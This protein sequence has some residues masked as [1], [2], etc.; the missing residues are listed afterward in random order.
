[1]V[2]NYEFTVFERFV[3][4]GDSIVGEV[5]HLAS[6][7]LCNEIERVEVLNLCGEANG[8]ILRIES[9][10]IVQSTMATDECRPGLFDC[11]AQR[12]DQPEPGNHHAT[13]FHYSSM[14]A[15]FR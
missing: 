11:I 7:L 3:R 10:D 6:F 2:I 13:L 14:S 4:G 12:C 15:T 8:E 5:T 1:M 9:T